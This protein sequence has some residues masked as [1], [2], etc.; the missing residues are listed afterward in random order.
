MVVRAG[1]NKGPGLPGGGNEEGA[2]KGATFHT[3]SLGDEEFEIPPISLDSDP[4]LAVADF[5]ELG[6]PPGPPQEPPFAPPYGV[7]PLDIPW[8]SGRG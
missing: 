6:D 5:D 1:G 2:A 8:E 7:Q 3:P 4:S